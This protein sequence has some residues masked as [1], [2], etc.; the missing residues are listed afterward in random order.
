METSQ[1]GL[2][3]WEL[4]GDPTEPGTRRL[5]GDLIKF[6][7]EECLVQP[8]PLP[9]PHP[10]AWLPLGHK[11]PSCGSE[12]GPL[13]TTLTLHLSGTCHNILIFFEPDILLPAARKLL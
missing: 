10:A 13:L 5:Q 8:I 12:E 7:P 9:D 6:C 3:D 1:R 2:G 11:A 4:R